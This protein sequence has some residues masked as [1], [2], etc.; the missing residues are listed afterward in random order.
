MVL[1]AIG[2]S[3]ALVFDQRR[4]A[5]AQPYL[6]KVMS[7]TIQQ[8]GVVHA[9]KSTKTVKSEIPE[10]RETEVVPEL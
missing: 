8:D 5:H 1:E 9:S 2:V 6:A 7:T 4:I 3:G 10:V